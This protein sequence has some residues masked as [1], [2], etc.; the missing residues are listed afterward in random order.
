MEKEVL[1]SNRKIKYILKRS[2]RAKYQR[3]V[4]SYDGK[5]TLTVPWWST[6]C[7]A[8]KFLSEKSPWIIKKLKHFEKYKNKTVLKSSRRD[9]KKY[10]ENARKLVLDRL[11]H[12]NQFYNFSWKSISIRNQKTRWG[13]CSCQGSLNFHYKIIFLPDELRDY[14]I[15]HELCHLKEFNHSGEFWDL[16][17]KTVPGYKRARRKLRNII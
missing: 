5:I 3:L 7:S 4:I 8:E 2:Q 10:K 15:I 16:V 11:N 9:Y 17:E 12:F 13:S 1:L 6:V 14:I